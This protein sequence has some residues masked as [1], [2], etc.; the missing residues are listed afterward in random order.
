MKSSYLAFANIILWS[1]LL[2]S[3]S[4]LIFHNPQSR[5]VTLAY[6]QASTR[7]LQKVPLYESSGIH[8]FLYFPHFALFFTPFALLPPIPREILWRIF[9]LLIFVGAVRKLT[10]SFFPLHQD[11]IFFYFSLLI[12]FSALA[13]IRNGQTNLAL[14]GSLV[15]SFLACGEKNW[16]KAAFFFFLS[17]ILKPIALFPFVYATIF[18]PSFKKTAFWLF[19][20][21]VLFP[22]FFCLDHPLYIIEQ[23]LLFMKRMTTVSQ[24]NVANFADIQGL[25][26][27]VHGELPFVLSLLIRSLA[28]IGIILLAFRLKRWSKSPLFF[29]M[30]LYSFSTAYLLLC[31]P[32]TEL[33][34]YVFLGLSLSFFCLYFLFVEKQK[35]IGL[36]LLAL[37]PFL[38]IEAF[39]KRWVE[40]GL[41]LKPLICLF[42]Q[43]L[44][45]WQL[46]KDKE[47]SKPTLESNPNSQ[48]SLL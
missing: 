39:G 20:L 48:S 38:G 33:N 14:S 2:L 47:Q 18:Y 7:F 42:S 21:F 31:N 29:S 12:L 5:T 24:P 37:Q 34:S 27:L 17:L 11:K 46:F 23:Y 40:I 4:L 25:F 36:F 44:L 28:A 30:L 1:V 32:R 16:L 3:L 41:W 22:F 19:L 8:G 43:I 26:H 6:V 13:S 10:T 15:L 45:S 35:T 9:S